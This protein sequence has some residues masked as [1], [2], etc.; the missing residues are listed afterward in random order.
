LLSFRWGWDA[1]QS[2]NKEQSKKSKSN[3]TGYHINSKVLSAYEKNKK[4]DTNT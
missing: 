4:I 3:N 2:L 1:L